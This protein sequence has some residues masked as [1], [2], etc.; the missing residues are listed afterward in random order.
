MPSERAARS[1]PPVGSHNSYS[2]VIGVDIGGTKVAAGV[3]DRGSGTISTFARLPMAARG[4]AEEGLAAVTAAI[5]AMLSEA[6]STQASVQGIGIC[7]PGPLDPNT[8]VVLN[9]PNVPCWR[10]FPLAAELERKYH[11]PVKVDNDANA[12]ALAETLW[13]AGRGHRIVF[14]ATLGTG[15]G[16]G[17]V[18]DGRIYHGRTGAAAEG[19]HVTIDYAGV[20]C[21]CGKRGCIEALAAGPAIAR[22]ARTRLGEQRPAKSMVLELAGGNLDAVTSERVGQAYAAGDALAQQVLQQ[23]VQYLSVWLG[24]VIDLLEPEVIIMGGGVAGMLQ[25]F[26][27]EITKLLPSCCVN[28]RCQE[29]PL[30]AA[31][32]GAD[33][34]IAGGAA[35]CAGPLQKD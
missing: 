10:N 23:V 1:L 19:G 17:I 20:P 31:C 8:G 35:L 30:V 6:G 5:D 18:F 34:G 32:Y 13:G 11:R 24:N 2:C 25:P 22:L 4:S 27:P 3:V 33:A 12:A 15:I 29:I 16:T 14:Y 21:A 9:P 28:Q 7:A 26:F